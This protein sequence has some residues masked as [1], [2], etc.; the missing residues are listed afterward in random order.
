M[1]LSS[2]SKFVRIAL[3]GILLVSALTGLAST[4]VRALGTVRYASPTGV[5]SGNCDSWANACTLVFALGKVT[6]GDQIWVKAG[7][8]KPHSNDRTKSFTLKNGVAVYGGFAGTEIALNQRNIS[9]NLTILSGDINAPNVH[10]DNSYHVVV[11]SGTGTSA[12]LDGVRII[13]GRANGGGTNSSG[14][15]LYNDSGSPTI[16]NVTFLIVGEPESL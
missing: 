2:S 14:G 16:R 5:I 15:G 1:K 6:S 12:K 7:T 10:T 9:A 11:A 13:R 8:H 4:N 3:L